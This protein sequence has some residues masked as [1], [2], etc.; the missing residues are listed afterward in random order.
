[1]GS[2]RS[3]TLVLVGNESPTALGALGHHANVHAA[4][5]TESTDDEVQRWVSRSSAPYVVHDRDPL[6][7]VAAAWVEFF[8]DLA[9][10]GTLDLE[11]DRATSGFQGGTLSMPD[12]YI[13]VD[14]ERLPATWKHWWLGVLPQAAPTRV[15]PWATGSTPLTRVLRSL[16]TGRSW[17]EPGPWLRDVARSVPDQ[18]GIANQKPAAPDL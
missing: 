14:P 13:V 11:V 18:I 5:L 12:Y 4:S 15:I 2:P 1:M 9:T 7:H 17:P 6:A 3:T 16:P 10:L 8:D